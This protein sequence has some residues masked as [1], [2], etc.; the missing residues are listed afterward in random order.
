MTDTRALLNRISAFRQRLEQMPRLL[1]D[2]T[3]VRNQ[4]PVYPIAE[5]APAKAPELPVQ[6]SSRVHQGLEE[7]RKL[8]AELRELAD[9]PLLKSSQ[10]FGEQ[11][12]LVAHHRE[13]MALANG[14]IRMI[15][16]LPEEADEQSLWC[17][18]LEASLNATG[19][20]LAMLRNTL[21]RTQHEWDL[22]D[23]LALLLSDIHRAKELPA[24]RLNEWIEIFFE[25]P[26][27]GP[28]R[29]LD[30]S[31]EEPSRYLARHAILVCRV[32]RRI[33]ATVEP[34][35]VRSAIRAALVSDVAMLRVRQAL[36]SKSSLSIEER[37]IVESHCV[38]GAEM[39]RKS[40][41]D[42]KLIPEIVAEHQERYDGSG[43]PNGLKSDQIRPEARLL[44]IADV[45]AAMIEDRPYRLGCDP[46][47]AL[48]D[49]LLMAE[50]GQHDSQY[51]SALLKV[52]FYPV[53]SVVELADGCLAAV[54][55]SPRS[56]QY[57][58]RPVVGLLKDGEGKV[59][60][61]PIV[62]DLIDAEGRAVVRTLSKAERRE[63][64]ARP[65]LEWAI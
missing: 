50:R 9:H 37:R 20:R 56:E 54:F 6:L 59:Y 28:L 40:F 23:R 43:Y 31:P 45:Y 63:K 17:E 53:G 3:T 64:L 11:A 29:W 24:E 1:P 10:T 32:L 44:A 51:I 49:S 25:E 13:T 4:P 60:P 52:G 36:L 19:Q 14:A 41:P 55:A 5:L 8:V 21:E 48:T 62:V 26:T 22:L 35:L 7:A 2:K 12:L 61:M 65:H 57:P 15:R 33:A 16:Y 34:E 47:T 38:R 46:R 27:S 39:I 30:V 58:T 42:L 18:S